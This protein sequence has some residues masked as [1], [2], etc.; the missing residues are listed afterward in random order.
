V[1][2]PQFTLRGFLLGACPRGKLWFSQVQKTVENAVKPIL[3]YLM[4]ASVVLAVIGAGFAAYGYFNR[5]VTLRVAVTSAEA[6][7]AALVTSLNRWFSANGRRY[8]LRTVVIDD[9]EKAFKS[10]IEGSADFISVRADKTPPPQLASVAVLYKEAAIV[11]ALPQSGVTTLAQLKGK[12]IGVVSKTVGDDPLLRTLLRQQ[13]VTDA[14]FMPLEVNQLQGEIQKRTIQAIAHVSPLNG[15]LT[16]ELRSMRPLRNM[17]G[18]PRLLGLEDAETVAKLDRYYEDFD[19]PA[20]ALRTAPPLPNETISTLAVS[21]HLVGRRGTASLFVGRFLAD[22]MDARRG[23]LADLP[24]AG[25][26]SA[27]D[28]EQNAVMPVH[29]GAVAFFDN[30]QVTLYEFLTEWSYVIL[31]AAGAIG[32]GLVGLAHRLWPDTERSSLSELTVA[33]VALKRDAGHVEKGEALAALEKRLLALLTLMG[34]KF[35]EGE[36]DRADVHTIL[37]SADMAE[38][39]LSEVRASMPRNAEAQLAK[40]Q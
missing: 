4:L 19:V 40:T 32:T 24:L 10:V 7:D 20:G 39:R 30:E 34:E 21:R 15:A 6:E 27:P 3:R 13:G 14:R 8:R 33:F 18:E 22:L 17:R 35:E 26:I 12:T 5:Q 2:P 9:I 28:T 36:I 1:T 37:M 38:R 11:V 16:M 25:Q 23:I 31:L 29:P